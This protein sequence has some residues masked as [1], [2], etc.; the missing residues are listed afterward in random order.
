MADVK[1]K[2]SALPAATNV[3]DADQFVIVQGGTTKKVEYTY[4]KSLLTGSDVV[5]GTFD[6]A[7]LVANVWTLNHAKNTVDVLLF[8]FDPDGYRQP[9]I[10]RK[11]DANNVT[12]DFGGAITGTWS[13]MFAYW[14]PG[15]A[16]APTELTEEIDIGAWNL[17]TDQFLNVVHGLDYTKILGVQAYLWNDDLTRKYNILGAV[18]EGGSFANGSLSIDDTNINLGVQASQWMAQ[19]SGGF[20]SVLNNRGTIYIRYKS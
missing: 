7:D 19:P 5:T 4:V 14:N 20:T 18:S 8:I 16:A 6:N 1:V 11:V 3:N 10:E 12:V 2:I 9:L 13:Y 15:V 17:S